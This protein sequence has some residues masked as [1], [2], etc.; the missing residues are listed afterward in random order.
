MGTGGANADLLA[1]IDLSSLG[2][3]AGGLQGMG[4]SSTDTTNLMAGLP[5]NPSLT[6][7]AGGAGMGQ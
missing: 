7:A 1:G 2:L 6:G 5:S 4:L 3:T